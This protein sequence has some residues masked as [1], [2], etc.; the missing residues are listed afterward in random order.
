[1]AMQKEQAKDALVLPAPRGVRRALGPEGIRAELV[2]T[3]LDGGPLSETQ[4][5]LA[6]AVLA[7]LDAEQEVSLAS[8]GDPTPLPPL[9]R[10]PRS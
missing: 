5:R 2:L 6:R 9:K 1:M 4:V 3:R 10:G 7:L 8:P